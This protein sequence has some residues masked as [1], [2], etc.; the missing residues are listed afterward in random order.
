MNT[1]P[2]VLRQLRPISYTKSRI[3]NH[4]RLTSAPTCLF[5]SLHIHCAGVLL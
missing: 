2:Q 5:A 4:L 1:P 3:I